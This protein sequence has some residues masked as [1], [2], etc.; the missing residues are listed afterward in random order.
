LDSCPAVWNVLHDAIVVGLT[1][2]VPGTVRLELDCDYLRDRFDQPG[3]RFYLALHD[4]TRFAYRPWLDEL[5]AID[6]LRLLAERR[7]WILRAEV[8][9]GYCRV[10]CNEHLPGGSGG[11]LEVSASTAEVHLDDGSL[12]SFEKLADVSEEYWTEWS[13]SSKGDPKMDTNR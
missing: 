13:L 8:V 1:G 10:H 11:T 9:A 6:D 2:A 7:L 4:C 5:T 12:V 3:N